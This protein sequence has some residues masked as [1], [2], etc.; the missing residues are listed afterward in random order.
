MAQ[1]YMKRRGCERMGE[2][3]KIY[4]IQLTD[5]GSLIGSTRSGVPLGEGNGREKGIRGASE[6]E[7]GAEPICLSIH[8]P[9]KKPGPGL[10]KCLPGSRV[11]HGITD[12]MTWSPEG[13]GGVQFKASFTWQSDCKTLDERKG[14]QCLR[15][16]VQEKVERSS[17]EAT[18][19]LKS[20]D[21]VLFCG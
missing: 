13:E 21:V 17:R 15:E 1:C 18:V 11:V 8:A 10:V 19:K 14:G 6:G 12:G 5:I 7:K 16:E 9:R 2:K 20:A 4:G 3:M